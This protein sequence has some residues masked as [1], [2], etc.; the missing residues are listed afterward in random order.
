MFDISKLFRVLATF[1]SSVVNMV[2]PK[3]ELQKQN[4]PIHVSQII[5][6]LP[7]KSDTTQTM[8][9]SSIDFFGNVTKFAGNCK[10]GHIY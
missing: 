3:A 4:F 5:N 2:F 10:F 8:K 9:F 1:K 6:R 7:K